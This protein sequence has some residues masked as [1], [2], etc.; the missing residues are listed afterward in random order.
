MN[1]L[2]WVWMW[3]FS[4]VVQN[5]IKW[6]C[7]C[8]FPSLVPH[9]VFCCY[10]CCLMCCLLCMIIFPVVVTCILHDLLQWL[11]L[12]FPTILPWVHSPLSSHWTTTVGPMGRDTKAC[13]V[14][15]FT[16]FLPCLCISILLCSSSLSTLT[17]FLSST[18]IILHTGCLNSNVAGLG[19]PCPSGVVLI[20]SNTM[21][22]SLLVSE[23]FLIVCFMN[24]MQAS[25][26]PLPRLWYN[27]DTAYSM[28]RLLQKLLNFSETKLLPA[29]DINLHSIP[30]SANTIFTVVMRFSADNPCILFITRNLLW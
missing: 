23:H 4:N 26:C 7:L 28:F 10:G 29:S 27:D 14:S 1:S 15:L 8:V 13:E 5:G 18:G 2:V 30:Y 6:I 16:S 17:G 20:C 25:T 12:P 22:T 11:W 3:I 19:R 9:V 21:C 24:F